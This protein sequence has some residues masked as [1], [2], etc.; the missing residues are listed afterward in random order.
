MPN[1]F[2]HHRKGRE[3]LVGAKVTLKSK[4]LRVG[5]MSPIAGTAAG[6]RTKSFDRY[7]NRPIIPPRPGCIKGKPPRGPTTTFPGPQ[8][9]SALWQ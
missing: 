3:V 1:V 8:A 4:L 7:R 6:E 9:A 2:E 5:T